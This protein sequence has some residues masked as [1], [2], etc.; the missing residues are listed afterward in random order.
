MLKQTL[1][2]V[3]ISLAASSAFAHEVPV[4]TG[5]QEY[6]LNMGELT[7][8]PATGLGSSQNIIAQDNHLPALIFDV[9][10]AG[11]LDV[12]TSDHDDPY[13]Q[14]L[15]Y[16]FKQDADG[17]DWTLYGAADQA[18]RIDAFHENNVYGVHITGYYNEIDGGYSDPGFTQY[19]DQ[20]TYIAIAPTL[21]GMLADMNTSSANWTGTITDGI[22]S[23]KLSS[24]FTWAHTLEG[25]DG[26][27]AGWFDGTQSLMDIYVRASAGSSAVIAVPTEPATVPVPGAVWLMGSVLAGFGAFG[28]KKAIAA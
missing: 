5:G 1:L 8:D 14:A 24:G 27:T 23:I 21:L 9:T 26:F 6:F 19:F 16:V 15:F 10:A 17:Q 7:I 11:N 2:A 13:S 25:Q 3:S 20:G 22:G 18:P 28:R 12:Y 4:A